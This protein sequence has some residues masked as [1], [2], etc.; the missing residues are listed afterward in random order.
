[1]LK[2]NEHRTE[3]RSAEANAT[4]TWLD[5]CRRRQEKQARR[6]IE[7]AQFDRRYRMIMGNIGPEDDVEYHNPFPG[8]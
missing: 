6:R 4:A 1:M 8:I 7:A 2:Y 3:Q 5:R